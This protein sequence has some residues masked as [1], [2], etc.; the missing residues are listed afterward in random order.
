V[1]P[2]LKYTVL[3]LALFIGAIWALTLL[4]ASPLVALIGAA[5]VSFLLSYL[6]LRGPRE[7]LAEQIAGRIERRRTRG[8]SAV[9]QDA[10]I[11][12]AVADRAAAEKAAAEKAAAD[13]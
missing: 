4:G 1:L 9:D 12:D 11:E 6:L 7:Q 13:D 8:P 5:V 2:L 3:R 10:A